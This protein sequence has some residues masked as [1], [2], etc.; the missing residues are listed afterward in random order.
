MAKTVLKR[1]KQPEDT[2][3]YE[4]TE[5]TKKTKIEMIVLVLNCGSSSIKHQLI[6]IDSNRSKIKAKGIV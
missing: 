6:D 3:G 2:G 5:I 1:L 4:K